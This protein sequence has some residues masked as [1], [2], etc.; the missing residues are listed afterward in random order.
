MKTIVITG[1]TKGIGLGLAREFL[2]R[3]CRVVISSRRASAVDQVC[4]DLETLYGTGKVTGLSCDITDIEQ[5]QAIWKAAVDHLGTVDIW[6]N[7]AGIANT[8]RKLW[9]LESQ[10]IP[11][12]VS[13]NLTGVIFG[14]QVAL[15]GMLAQ[16]S[17]QVYNLEGFGSDDMLVNGLSVYGATKR[18]VRYFSEAMA[19]EVED[20]PVQVGTISPGIVLTDF[21]VDDMRKMDPEQLEITKAVYNVLADDVE[22]VTQFLVEELLVNSENGRRIMWMPEE[23]ANAYF[24]DEARLSRDLFSQY[25]L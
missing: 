15:Q 10:E 13:T 2:K 24:A 9:E 23:K 22:T 25:G 20:R 4:T 14:T 7:N 18:G 21:L 1:S 17:G 5:V 11:R 12:V 19:Q 3:D 8:T 16:G 6:L